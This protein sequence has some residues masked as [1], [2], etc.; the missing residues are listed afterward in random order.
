MTEVL[1]AGVLQ[2]E[3]TKVDAVDGTGDVVTRRIA[4]HMFRSVRYPSGQGKWYSQKM[5][6][7]SPEAY[8]AQNFEP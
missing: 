8:E 5:T 1:K 4:H 2:G 7:W 3:S 6:D